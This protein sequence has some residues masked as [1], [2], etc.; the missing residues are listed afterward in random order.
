MDQ[1]M[2][3]ILI[4]CTLTSP[5]RLIR[6]IRLILQITI[7]MGCCFEKLLTQTIRLSKIGQ[8]KKCLFSTEICDLDYTNIVSQQKASNR[9][10]YMHM[11]IDGVRLSLSWQPNN[12]PSVVSPHSLTVVLPTG[13]RGSV[14]TPRMAFDSILE[15]FQIFFKRFKA[16]VEVLK[17]DHLVQEL[18]IRSCIFPTLQ[19]FF[20]SS[21]IFSHY[22][23]RN[24]PQEK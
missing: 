21:S 10:P 24:Q 4:T 22:Y 11:N 6:S 20:E 14:P 19:I 9:I 23:L 3:L 17:T 2:L 12:S 7:T 15:P 18:L 13:L 16:F 8:G 1:K 5:S